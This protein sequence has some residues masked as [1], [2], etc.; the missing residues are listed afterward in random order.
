MSDHEYGNSR[1]HDQG[2]ICLSSKGSK[3][4]STVVVA[5][6]GPEVLSLSGIIIEKCLKTR[7]ILGQG[8]QGNFSL[9]ATFLAFTMKSE[10]VTVLAC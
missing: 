5:Y 1:C 7:R 2:S 8:R 9:V 3:R 10:G 6:V 4:K